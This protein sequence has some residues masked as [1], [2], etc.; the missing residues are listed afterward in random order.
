VTE[1]PLTVTINNKTVTEVKKSAIPI[2]C[3]KK[4]D[5]LKQIIVASM[6]NLTP[7]CKHLLR[8]AL[9]LNKKN[10]RTKKI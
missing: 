1:G 4:N 7:K 3:K 9:K 5:L 6:H 10:D 8:E 2:R